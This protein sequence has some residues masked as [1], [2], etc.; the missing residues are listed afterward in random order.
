MT[1]PYGWQKYGLPLEVPPLV[2]P[3]C[4][5]CGKP[6]D[7]AGQRYCKSCHAAY[8]RTWRKNCPRQSKAYL[9]RVGPMFHMKQFIHSLWELR[10]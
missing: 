8:M 1:R 6:R 9:G 4:S 3:L 10:G 5:R 7:K 2:E